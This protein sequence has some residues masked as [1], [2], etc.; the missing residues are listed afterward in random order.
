M[1]GYYRYTHT[2]I[3]KYAKTLR[4]NMTEEERI[5]WVKLRENQLGYKFRRQYVIDNYIV[6]FIC[7]EKRLI[8]ELDGSQHF[9]PNAIHDDRK[10]TYHLAQKEFQVLRFTNSEIRQNLNDVLKI[11]YFYLTGEI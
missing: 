6:D 9:K 7:L 4:K 11:I 10:R 5:L 1:S 3:A 8:I 2:Q